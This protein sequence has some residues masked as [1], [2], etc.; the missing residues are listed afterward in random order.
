M[1]K[2]LMLIISIL[3]IIGTTGTV[4]ANYDG[5][6]GSITIGSSTDTGGALTAELSPGVLANVATTTNTYGVVTVNTKAGADA[7]G[8][9]VHSASGAIFMKNY[10]SEPS[11]VDDAVAG[12]VADTTYKSK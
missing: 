10:S 1:K 2:S 7:I 11:D 4:Y 6:G 5:S 12:S 3:A 8:Y 9:N